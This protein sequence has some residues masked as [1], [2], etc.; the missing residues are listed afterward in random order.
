MFAMTHLLHSTNVFEHLMY[1]WPC[2][3]LY[4]GKDK[5]EAERTSESHLIWWPSVFLNCNTSKLSM[6]PYNLPT[7][8]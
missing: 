4:K 7:P 5:N 1:A 3:R 8:L 2:S 6:R